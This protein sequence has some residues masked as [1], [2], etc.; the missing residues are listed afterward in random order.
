MT[1]VSADLGLLPD[2]D[3]LRP[4]VWI[5]DTLVVR[6]QF[7]DEARKP[8]EPP[9]PV[10]FLWKSPS[11]VVLELPGVAVAGK[12]GAYNCE[13]QVPTTGLWAVRADGGDGQPLEWTEV[14]V[15]PEPPV[16]SIPQQ[17]I[18]LSAVGV[19][20]VSTRGTHLAGATIP[21]FP[22]KATLE[23]TDTIPGV[24]ADGNSVRLPGN[25]VIDAALATVTPAVEQVTQTAATVATQAGEVAGNAQ[26]AQEAAEAATGKAAEAVAAAIQAEGIANGL[27]IRTDVP[28]W[29]LALVDQ[30]SDLAGGL[31]ADGRTLSLGG[32][33]NTLLPDNRTGRLSTVDGATALDLADGSLKVTGPNGTGLGLANVPTDSPIR[34]A[35]VDEFDNIGFYDS[36]V[37]S[38]FT[39]A[40]LGII[41]SRA[42]ARITVAAEAAKLPDPRRMCVVGDSITQYGLA[43][44]SVAG[45]VGTGNQGYSG[46]LPMLLRRRVELLI[47]DNY[48]VAGNRSEQML[49]RAAT[50]AAIRCG[51]ALILA[52][53]ND[54]NQDIPI[55]TCLENIKTMAR[56]FLAA[57][58]QVI[59]VPVPPRT[60]TLSNGGNDLR[61]L[62]A[63][64]NAQIK[65]F[66][67]ATRGIR[68]A[69]W[70]ARTVDPVTGLAR[71]G[72][73]LDAVHP[74]PTGAFHMARTVADLMLPLIPTEEPLLLG[75]DV[76][77][78]WSAQ[79]PW[80][81][82]LANGSLAGTGGALGAGMAGSVPTG[83]TAAV[84]V[85]PTSGSITWS[86]EARS[87]G[88][89]G[90]RTRLVLAAHKAASVAQITMT[91]EVPLSGGSYAPGDVVRLVCEMEVAAGTQNIHAVSLLLLEDNGASVVTYIDQCHSSITSAA[92]SKM[93]PSE[94]Y[95]GVLATDPLTIRATSGGT[96]KLTAQIS[97]WANGTASAGAT[98]SA[99][100]SRFSLRKVA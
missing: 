10:V 42:D 41:D 92:A 76:N 93:L 24:D 96:P 44:A 72:F 3:V 98:L 89:P 21:Q 87:D 78:A 100:F 32:L 47:A 64:L 23:A 68:Y 12:V 20:A 97:V 75:A 61:P 55:G 60:D 27:T 84:S 51:W 35:V 22:A 85:A 95:S 9:G 15:V 6:V 82:K 69:D 40:Q 30:Y 36:Q 70:T 91:Q 48:G 17:S 73:L 18:W 8:S 29:S 49:G 62:Q 99:A 43:S 57:G 38:E 86:K 2:A 74:G 66:A 67:M 37:S 54:L 50:A 46:W 7:R 31:T 1:V 34:F 81:N 4:R 53:T 5:G 26:A 79:N 11:N 33:S 90:E 80:G 65:A 88:L 63:S 71:A 77:E 83:W 59:L 56:G 52:G 45:L 16:G 58:A 19:A 25:A 13:Y 39:T 28:G 94:G 14:T